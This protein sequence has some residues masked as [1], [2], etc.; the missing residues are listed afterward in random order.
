MW[1]ALKVVFSMIFSQPQAVA[2]IINTVTGKVDKST[3]TPEERT[4]F[5]QGVIESATRLM[6]QSEGSSVSRRFIVQVV[7]GVWAM[8]TIAMFIAIGMEAGFAPTLTTYMNENVTPLMFV[9][10]AFYF[11]KQVIQTAL[12]VSGKNAEKLEKARALAESASNLRDV[13]KK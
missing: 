6:E 2:N 11:G 13:L 9:L 3:M 8:G 12:E 10:V 5:N 4:N 7:F 1:S